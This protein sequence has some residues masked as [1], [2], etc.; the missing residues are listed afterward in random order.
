M[1]ANRHTVGGASVLERQADVALALGCRRIWLFTA[2]QDG[3]AIR[4]QRFVEAS[5][6]QFRLIQRGRQLLASVRQQD[7]LLVLAEGLLPGDRTALA[8]LQDGPMILTLPAESGMASGFER[9]DRESCWAGAMILPGRVVERL[10]ELGED[11]E[12]V[13]AL[14]RAGRAARV[15]ERSLPEQWLTAGNWSLTPS[16]VPVGSGASPDEPGT[17]QQQWICHPIG[18][19][20]VGRARLMIAIAAMGAF[21]GF[22][23]VAALLWAEPAL[24]LLLVALSGLLLASWISARKQGDVRVFSAMVGGTRERFLPMIGEPIGVLA[25]VAGLHTQFGW[26]STLYI[27]ALTLTTWILAGLG[28]HRLSRILADRSLL[29]LACGLGGLAGVW[30]A[31]PAL[32]SALSLSAILL[33]M[34]N[35]PAITQA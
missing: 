34:R 26:P 11:I 16:K 8:V 33:N 32:A 23:G 17:W 24:A 15:A 22:G 19:R 4:T 21:A 30:I 6:A 28:K 1:G 14:L 3:L 10:D 27:A 35:Q 5:G 13:S 12:P 2:E 29:W 20:L 7:E 25:L 31:G 9:I 18:A